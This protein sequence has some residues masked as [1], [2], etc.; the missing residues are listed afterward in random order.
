MYKELN[1]ICVSGAHYRFNMENVERWCLR[2]PDDVI[3][4]QYKSGSYVEFIR[5]NVI[6]IEVNTEEGLNEK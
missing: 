2:D 3:H 6:A 4:I 1:I 5:S